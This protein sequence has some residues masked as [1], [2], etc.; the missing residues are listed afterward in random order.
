MTWRYPRQSPLAHLHLAAR[1]T[2]ETAAVTLCERPP[3][4]LAILRGEARDSDFLEGTRRVLGLALPLVAGRSV[5]TGELCALWLGPDEWLLRGPEGADLVAPLH[6]AL[7]GVM[8]QAVEIG[9]AR[10]VLG[11][12]GGSA[13]DVL[14]KGCSLD[15]HPTV[16]RAGG[17]AQTLLGRVGVLIHLLTEDG[18]V[19]DLYVARSHADYL[20]RW[21]EDAALEYG[22][23]VAAEQ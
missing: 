11:L 5:R 22:F 15:L 20:W 17:C 19:F 2:S 8:H 14:L 10:A 4:S 13:R 21:L 12:A 9:D 1:E 16:F 3:V 18:P 7:A 6:R 23:A